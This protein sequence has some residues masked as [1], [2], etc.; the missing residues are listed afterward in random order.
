MNNHATVSVV[1]PSY[2]MAWSIVRAIRSCQKQTYS[3]HEIVVVDDGSTDETR[4]IVAAE[5]SKDSR[6]RY[7]APPFNV[8]CAAAMSMGISKATGEWIAFLDADDELTPN[9]IADRIS[10]LKARTGEQ[11]GLIYGH[12][13]VNR[14]SDQSLVRFRELDGHC[15]PY[16]CKELSLCAQIVMMVRRDCFSTAGFPSSEFPS[17]TDD[18]MVLTVA[19]HFPVACVRKPVAIIHS[20]D[21]PTR[22][23]NDPLRV[24]RGVAMLVSKYKNDVVR[25]HGRRYL[26][27]WWLRIAR[28]YLQAEIQRLTEKRRNAIG[29]RLD[30]RVRSFVRIRLGILGRIY[31]VLDR[32]LR[33]YFD[34]IYFSFPLTLATGLSSLAAYAS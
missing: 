19:K 12:V 6:I 14:V 20:H 9:S 5:A 16:L 11:P 10:V 34:Y 27:L 4:Q 29:L 18:D 7:I 17:S 31:R 2:N 15:Y 30:V 13:Y 3:A 8:G 28:A 26:A 22:M 32:F 1:I 23:T 33:R 25:H 21:S 24:A